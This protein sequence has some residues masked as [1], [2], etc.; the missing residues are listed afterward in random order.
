MSNPR[1]RLQLDNANTI[2]Y[3]NVLLQHYTQLFKQFYANNK[4]VSVLSL[5]CPSQ[6]SDLTI[7]SPNHYDCIVLIL[8]LYYCVLL[9]YYCILFSPLFSPIATI[10]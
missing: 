6:L 9:L 10:F 7:S 5:V 4:K 3:K 1:V 2:H 8:V